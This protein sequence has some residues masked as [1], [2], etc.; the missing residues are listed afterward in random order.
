M[1]KAV[2]ISVCLLCLIGFVVAKYWHRS[3]ADNV[4]AVAE[5]TPV[6][7]APVKEHN[8]PLQV[9][10]VGQLLAPQTVMLKSKVSGVIRYVG[11]KPGDWVNK[12]QVLVKIDDGDQKT[13]LANAIATYQMNRLKYKRY[14]RLQNARASAV[15]E[16]DVS[17]ALG[18]MKADKA[19]VSN[20]KKMLENTV[21]KAPFSG[22]VS[23]LSS[24]ASTSFSFGQII[25]SGSQLAL[26]AFVN[27]G[28]N[29]VLISNPTNMNV[30]Y[31]VPQIYSQK[32]QYHQAV[33]V[34]STA[35]PNQVFHGKVIFI[36]PVVDQVSQSYRVRATIENSKKE[37]RSGMNVFVNQVLDPN[38]R[39]IAIPGIA[40]TPALTGDQ[41]YV[42]KQGKVAS[43]AV[44][45]GDRHG[46]QVEIKKGLKVGQSVIVGGVSKVHPGSRVKLVSS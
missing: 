9:N 38:R 8:I 30:S 11:F 5:P 36:S 14:Q 43:V 3:V 40:V 25:S 28:D 21:V 6:R 17:T 32:I 18:T 20:A 12:G 46:N 1:K 33:T 16:D 29:L 31:L 4:A 24:L 13:K 45:T 19:L 37:L 34:S 23:S 35:Y 22:Y 10:A 41:V 2:F 26:G 15:S 39:V 42:I 27:T 44:V 7:V